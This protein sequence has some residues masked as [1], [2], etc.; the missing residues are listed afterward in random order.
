M[1]KFNKAIAVLAL[2]SSLVA[3]DDAAISASA[4]EGLE[5]CRV[6]A[7]RLIEG[8]GSV[9]FPSSF[10]D[11]FR[12][13]IVVRLRYEIENS[14]DRG[15]VRCYFDEEDLDNRAFTRITLND[16]EVPFEQLA[17]L[18]NEARAAWVRTQQ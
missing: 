8:S 6:A 15:T 2:S 4:M 1:F 5:M 14:G 18:T 16:D 7:L 10:H 3:C 11:P 13:P 12:D 9:S 17:G